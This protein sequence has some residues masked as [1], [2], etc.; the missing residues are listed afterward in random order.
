MAL[1]VKGFCPMCGKEVEAKGGGR[2]FCAGS[3]CRTHIS[4]SDVKFAKAQE[5]GQ[6]CVVSSDWVAMMAPV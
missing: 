4:E 1:E 3:L 6:V 2:Y 5:S